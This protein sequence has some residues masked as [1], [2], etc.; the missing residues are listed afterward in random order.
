MTL[1]GR[2]GRHA[3]S[4]EDSP[5]TAVG[6]MLTAMDVNSPGGAMRVNHSKLRSSP[7][8]K[9]RKRGFTSRRSTRATRTLAGSDSAAWCDA[10]GQ[11]AA[12]NGGGGEAPI[13]SDYSSYGDK[14][15]S[16]TKVDGSIGVLFETV[17]GRAGAFVC[18]LGEDKTAE[19]AGLLVGD[20]VTSVNGAAV[21]GCK[22]AADALKAVPRDGVVAL[23]VLCGTRAVALDKTTGIKVGITCRD[24]AHVPRG[25][26]LERVHGDS[27]ASDVGLLAGEVLLSVNGVLVGTHQVGPSP[28]RDPGP[29]PGPGPNHCSPAPT[30]TRCG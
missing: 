19:R 15:L 16:I 14:V 5:A 20:T 21:R 23:T 11:R 18:A 29:G 10:G 4:G 24:A 27:L 25:V 30:R 22:E 8:H 13:A 12:L 9:S 1:F 6:G 7:F 26:L 3:L 2:K 17:A 28:G